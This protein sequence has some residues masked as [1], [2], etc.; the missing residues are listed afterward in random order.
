[1]R[2]IKSFL[3]DERGE[4]Q[5]IG[6][7]IVTIIGVGVAAWFGLKIL[8]GAAAGKKAFRAVKGKKGVR[9]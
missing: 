7:G 3:K 9:K 2:T 1:M 8:F 4:F 5:F 6:V